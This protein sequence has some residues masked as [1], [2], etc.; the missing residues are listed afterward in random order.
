[1]NAET[2]VNLVDDAIEEALMASVEEADEY[3]REQGLDPQVVGKRMEDA[4]KQAIAQRQ[5]DQ[6]EN[7]DA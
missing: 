1:M 4:A 5:A 2:L 6:R 3:L 7:K